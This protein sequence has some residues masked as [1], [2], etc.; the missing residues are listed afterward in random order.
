MSDEEMAATLGRLMLERSAA[1]KRLALLREE[2]VRDGKLMFE[3]SGPLNLAGLTP[4]VA[5]SSIAKLDQLAAAGGLSRLKANLEAFNSTMTR[6]N[7]L[8]ETIDQAG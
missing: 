1:R 3:I 6:L 5:R 7:D 4:D 8:D 2:I